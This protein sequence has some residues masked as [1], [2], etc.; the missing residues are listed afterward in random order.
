[1][2]VLKGYQ[3]N[4]VIL[5]LT[6]AFIFPNLKSEEIKKENIMKSN[7]DGTHY[8]N[9]SFMQSETAKVTLEG[10]TLQGKVL[11]IGCGTGQTTAYMASITNGTVLGID[12][13]PSMID[14]AQKTY[15]DFPNLAFK[16]ADATIW[17][18]N[19]EEYDF[20]V[21]FSCL[22][23]IENLPPI[24]NNIAKS[25]KKDGQF[26]ACLSPYSHF[27]YQ[28]LLDIANS[29]KWTKHLKNPQQK[30]WFPYTVD[31]FKILLESSNL[32]PISIYI[33]N[34]KTTSKNRDDFIAFL[35]GWITVV[36]HVIQLPKNLKD[37]FINDVADYFLKTVN[38]KPDG[39]FEYIT[40]YLMVK[41]K[42]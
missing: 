3:M 31:E 35:K 32:K 17:P 38:I 16:L 22:H 24:I 20:I 41:A 7:W 13:S 40:P 9:N 10:I 12:N 23:W 28:P 6:L 25:L 33:W 29:D 18:F 21:S 5:F 27:L 26:V 30:P 15:G 2:V 39:S 42:K 14:F 4:L 8:H 11:D 36:P 19:L 37:E 34:K 1:M